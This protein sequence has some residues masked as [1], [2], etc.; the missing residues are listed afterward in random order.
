MIIK[1]KHLNLCGS[2]VTMPV[3]LK[4]GIHIVVLDQESFSNEFEVIEGGD[5][6]KQFVSEC[7]VFMKGKEKVI[8]IIEE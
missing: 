1:V 2:R 5:V 4:S 7:S 6:I 8:E 3:L